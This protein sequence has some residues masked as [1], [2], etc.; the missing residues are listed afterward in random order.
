MARAGDQCDVVVI[1]AGVLGCAVARELSRYALDVLVLERA[2]DVGE[3]SSKA[4]SGIVHAGFQP[5]AGSLK[6]ASCVAGNGLFDE[7]ARDL[8][9]P[10]SR[11]GGM[12]VAFSPEGEEKLRAKADRARGNGLGDLPFITGA[13]ARALE[14]RLSER[15]TRAMLAP[16]TAVVSP[17]DLVLGLAENAGRNGVRFRFN[18]RVE[19]IEA[20]PSAASAGAAA[21]AAGLP[22]GCR[23]LLH[24]DDGSSVAARCVV[25]MAGDEACTLDAQVHPADYEVRARLGEYLVFDKQDPAR[26]ITHVIYQAADSDEGGTLIAPTVEGNLLVGPTSR[27]VRDFSACGST[28][29]GLDHV[30]RVARKVIP[31]LDFSDVIR[32]FAGARTNIVNVPKELKDFV[33]RLS[34]PGF[35]SA[36]GIKNPGLTAS[37][38]LARRA[39]E[40]L[41]ADGLP[42]VADAAFDPHRRRWHPFLERD[43]AEQERLMQRDGSFGRVVCRCEGI[44][45]GDVRAVLASP[46]PP[47]TL[48]G[49]KRRLRCGMGRCQ[50]SFCEPRLV[51][52]VA[53]TLGVPAEQVPFGE[54]GGRLVLRSVK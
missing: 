32:N 54:A 9:I 18:T 11:C 22:A 14:P 39:V 37:P 28:A 23:W 29:A 20:A 5:R 38:A 7:L 47:T 19:R 42:L 45:V 49:I 33:V 2:H 6:G 51:E 12:M 4:N 34:A 46:L 8:D 21:S 10:F 40:L 43:G 26:A 25:N 3:G 24:A 53:E 13:E 27:N 35:V 48:S 44:T 50:G 52:A 17:F 1:G 41:A 36:L 30:R 16:T 31:D 15:V